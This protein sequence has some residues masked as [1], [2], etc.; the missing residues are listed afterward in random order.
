MKPTDEQARDFAASLIMRTVLD[1]DAK[2]DPM[3]FNLMRVALFLKPTSNTG[4]LEAMVALLQKVMPSDAF[5]SMRDQLEEAKRPAT[6]QD[7]EIGETFLRLKL[8]HVESEV[9]M[10]RCALEVVKK[11]IAAAERASKPAGEKVE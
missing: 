9:V 8:H 6:T 11:A 4:K 5:R 10:T 1:D 3:R 2:K 7:L